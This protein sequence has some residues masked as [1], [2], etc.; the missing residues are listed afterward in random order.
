[1]RQQTVGFLALSFIIAFAL[2]LVPA[3][4]EQVA[5][6]SDISTGSIAGSVWQDANRNGIQEPYEA[7]MTNYPVYLQQVGLEV[8]GA[9]VAVTYTDSEGFFLFDNVELGEYKV[10]PEDGTA[11][12]TSIVDVNAMATLNLPVTRSFVNTLFLPYA[13]K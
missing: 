13:S 10:Y 1:M 8:S 3:S 7:P 4:A 2:L 6:A 5:A 9:I 11:V 12:L